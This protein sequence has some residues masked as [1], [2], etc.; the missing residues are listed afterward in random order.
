[1]LPYHPRTI[2][3]AGT[4]RNSGKTTLACSLI[5]LLRKSGEVVAV[6]ISSHSHS[7][8]EIC[9]DV[10][11]EGFKIWLET[12][13]LQGKDTYRMLQAGAHKVF[14]I[15]SVQESLESA[16]KTVR[17]MISLS[18]VIICES[19]GLRHI[20]EPALFFMGTNEKAP[21]ESALSLLPLADAVLSFEQITT[22][23]TE[24]F[25][26]LIKMQPSLF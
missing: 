20:I 5:Q 10:S 12:A 24:L 17:Q 18:A 26:K 21:K 23:E 4:G 9:P 1:M 14:Y 16:F 3:I 19:G 15:E 7:N 6:K 11:G 25:L 8:N 22:A 2:L 13:P